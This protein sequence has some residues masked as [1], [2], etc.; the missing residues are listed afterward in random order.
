MR[1]L[2]GTLAALLLAVQAGTAGAVCISTKQLAKIPFSFEKQETENPGRKSVAPI[3]QRICVRGPVFTRGC[4]ILVKNY[5]DEQGPGTGGGIC[6]DTRYLTFSVRGPSG[7]PASV[8]ANQ[9]LDVAITATDRDGFVV[10]QTLQ[11]GQVQWGVDFEEANYPAPPN[12]LLSS[13]IPPGFENGPVFHLVVAENPVFASCDTGTRYNVEVTGNI[14][15]CGT[16]AS[17][18]ESKPA[19]GESNEV[20]MVFVP[21][22][23]KVPVECTGLGACPDY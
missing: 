4:S 23:A 14:P 8:P 16:L 5:L 10:R 13:L 1:F 6:I 11:L 7:A 19:N 3:L 15:G 20:P 2:V 21:D 17:S 22:P 18:F 9:R 12:V